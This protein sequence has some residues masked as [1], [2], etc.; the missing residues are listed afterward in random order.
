METIILLFEAV[1]TVLKETQRKREQKSTNLEIERN[2]SI[3][4]WTQT[5]DVQYYTFCCRITLR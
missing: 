2:F 4:D 3:R 5:E 1:Y